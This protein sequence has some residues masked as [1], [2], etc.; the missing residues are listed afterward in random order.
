MAIRNSNTDITA[1]K[2]VVD[3]FSILKNASNFKC[4]LT[5]A[6][7]AALMLVSLSDVTAQPN[8]LVPVEGGKGSDGGTSTS[9]NDGVKNFTPQQID[10]IREAKNIWKE[11]FS[12]EDEEASSKLMVNYDS[13]YT[14][15]SATRKL[16]DPDQKYLTR[17][18]SNDFLSR[19]YKMD[20]AIYKGIV[21]HNKYYSTLKLVN[22]DIT[23]NMRDNIQIIDESAKG[24]RFKTTEIFNNILPPFVMIDGLKTKPADYEKFITNFFGNNPELIYLC[25]KKFVRF[26]ILNQYAK[27][28]ALHKTSIN[29]L[30]FRNNP[31]NSATKTNN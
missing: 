31:D 3:T 14:I 23:K 17:V 29:K 6:L 5:V 21:V 22:D 25:S 2:N 18:Y 20:T 10:E 26:I 19:I 9:T 24:Y 28:M 8:R 16:S 1:F 11:G 12:D 15:Y 4:F 27:L 7:F 30:D 13:L